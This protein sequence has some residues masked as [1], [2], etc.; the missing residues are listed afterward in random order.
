MA[1]ERSFNSLASGVE[2][3]SGANSVFDMRWRAE[4]E[5]SSMASVLSS[6]RLNQYELRK[7]LDAIPLP[8]FTIDTTHTVT[9]WNKAC[10]Q[11]T[12]IPSKEMLG[13][14]DPWRGFYPNKR[15][16]LADL[17]VDGSSEER[18]ASLYG[19]KYSRS[20]IFPEI[21]MGEDF[22]PGLGQN[23][24]WIFFSASPLRDEQEN[25]IGAIEILTDI[26]QCKEAEE[27][28]KKSEM[29]YR[30]LFEQSALGIM[31]NDSEYTIWDVNPMALEILGY[32][33]EEMIGVNAA[34]LIHPE[35]LRQSSMAE[36]MRR[37][38]IGE[39]LQ[40][41]RRFL[42]KDGDYIPVEISFRRLMG[43]SEPA[44][45]LVMFHDIVQR[46]EAEERIYQLAYSDGLTG[47]PNRWLFH[48]R[49]KQA[50]EQYDSSKL[51]TVVLLVDI[52]RLRSVNDTLGQQAGDELIKEVCDRLLYSVGEDDTVARMAGDEFMILAHGIQST[53]KAHELSQ[54][55]LDRINQP[56]DLHGSLIYPNAS[57]GFTLVPD[58]PPSPDTLIK[59]ADIA[60]SGAKKKGG[61][62]QGF[63]EQDDSVSREFYLER[64][65]KSALRNEE[66]LVFCQPK[67]DLRTGRILGVE[68][69]LRW[70]H[71]ERGLVP[72][73]EFI[74]VLERTGMIA[75]VDQWVIRRVCE[76]LVTWQEQ[77]L[78]L[79]CSANLSAQELNNENIVY[80]I[81][82]ALEK[83]GLDGRYL[84]VELT[85]TEIMGNV[86]QASEILRTLS[87]WGLRIALD[88]FGKGY[89]CLSY[90]HQLDI[91]VIKIDKQFV[92]GLP[93][94]RGAVTLV[95]TIIAMA[96]NLGK[97]VL[98]EGVESED[99]A[100][101]LRD[102]GCDYGQG[103]LWGRPQPPEYLTLR[104]YL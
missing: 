37:L 9:S 6:L 101:T 48:E 104:G 81:K 55:I 71:P 88:D 79:S 72:P 11:M 54:R 28:F 68:A 20:E 65:L 78:Y 3:P 77:G 31:L 18:M 29:K 97:K 102:L 94:D 17:I 43:G 2:K 41:E 7:V 50:I 27:A 12:G 58:V 22:F 56:L 51:K 100:R 61:K 67:I 60:V 5:Q 64:D 98:A 69:L 66:F 84:E 52:N 103:F 40:V 80:V 34:D 36:N 4:V 90:L 24:V 83:T 16:V 45:H 85:E 63:M 38:A 74:P 35:D 70:N 86:E 13:T 49:L 47:L 10:N 8:I 95:Q 30:H 75:A 99:Q 76:Q 89:S 1:K 73:N 96:H 32:T 93:E 62:I 26:S 91:S 39:K 21:Y 44:D 57:I 23:G 15:P 59:Q 25:I 42:K 33:R 92:D 19:S 14:S 53:E 46:K 87:G 82:E